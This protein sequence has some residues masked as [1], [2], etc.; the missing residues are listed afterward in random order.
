MEQNAKRRKIQ[1]APGAQK[2][3][4]IVSSRPS[5]KTSIAQQQVQRAQKVLGKG[6]DSI[7]SRR[8][9]SPHAVKW[10]NSQ[11]GKGQEM[12]QSY[13]SQKTNIDTIHR[14]IAESAVLPPSYSGL[15]SY[16]SQ[17]SR[18]PVKMKMLHVDGET[19]TDTIRKRPQELR[20][21]LDHVIRQL[22]EAV[23]VMH[24]ANV[25]H[26]DIKPHNIMVRT[27]P[28]GER[29][30]LLVTLIDFGHSMSRQF[31][32]NERVVHFRGTYLYMAPELLSGRLSKG[33]VAPMSWD[34]YRACD[35]WS[36]GVVI[37]MMI[38]GELPIDT[39]NSTIY[40]AN[41]SHVKYFS[42]DNRDSIN[43]FN[44]FMK[45]NRSVFNLLF[46]ISDDTSVLQARDRWIRLLRKLISF[47]PEERLEYVS[48][49]V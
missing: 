46:N 2:Q 26:M 30:R 12:Y 9:Y 24:E 6:A 33:P 15:F 5:Q 21:D 4:P 45:K 41:P 25:V 20:A 34:D 1:R 35:L 37:Y 23:H 36:L 27:V 16:I 10:P 44:D 47:Y 3:P 19:L 49:L 29:P 11:R 17:V 7:V 32:E 48:V 38:Y 13:I 18:N 28:G 39:Y 40:R 14:Y 31:L 22:V 43:A 8:P 42:R